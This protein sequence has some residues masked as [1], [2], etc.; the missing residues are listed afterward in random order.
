MYILALLAACSFGLSE[1]ED[2]G[3]DEPTTI[4]SIRPA[5]G[6]PRG[7]TKVTIKGTGFEGDV[8]VTF[9][10]LEATEVTVV[11]DDKLTVLTPRV[12]MG[13]STE[14]PV[15][16]KVV[17][18]EN[19]SDA[20]VGGFTYQEGGGDDSG[21][22]DSGPDTDDTG[23]TDTTVSIV[24]MVAGYVTYDWSLVYCAG[25]F[26]LE[27]TAANSVSAAAMF[28]APADGSW[29]DELPA[30]DSCALATGDQ[31]ASTGIDAGTSL[32]MTYDTKTVTLTGSAGG[33]GTTYSSG[34]LPPDSYVESVA[35]DVVTAGG[36]D[37][38]AL[39]LDDALSTTSDFTS[40]TPSALLSRVSDQAWT[41]PFSTSGTDMTWSPSGVG[42][43]V[44]VT[45]ESSSS[46][47]EVVNCRFADDGSATVP[48]S[49]LA[50]WSAGE[51]LTVHVIRYDVTESTLSDGTI[52]E[53]M[54]RYDAVG[55]A[56]VQ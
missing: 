8:T 6:P 5:V 13:G 46:S 38:E 25:C 42:D 56:V 53:L 16:V 41:A 35:W 28:H 30:E 17:S 14:I 22:D 55:T 31:L 24:G 7:G 49:A 18:D 40:V 12:S 43:F 2:D 54:G 20:V 51:E 34:A 15:E 47:A 50:A 36:A 44:L 9:G 45:L 48:G 27:D 10:G 32:T 19:G 33:S 1:V 39:T 26:G 11:D 21:G 4:A 23:D 37:L 3:N 29:L 52:I